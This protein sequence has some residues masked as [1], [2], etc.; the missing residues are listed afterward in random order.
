MI[1]R[2]LK[3]RKRPQEGPLEQ[4]EP[5][6]GIGGR[7]HCQEAVPFMSGKGDSS[8]CLACK[9]HMP[10]LGGVSAVCL[11]LAECLS[12][13]TLKHKWLWDTWQGGGT[14]LGPSYQPCVFEKIRV[15]VKAGGICQVSSGMKRRGMV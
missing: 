14:G 4:L 3:G 9:S 11:S 6:L 2:T 10:S 13:W 8:R 1:I 5:T 7:G 15:F 12:A